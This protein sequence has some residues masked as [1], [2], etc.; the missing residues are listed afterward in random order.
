ML[1]LMRSVARANV[2]QLWVS[3]CCVVL[4]CAFLSMQ[5]TS[6]DTLLVGLHNF[7]QVNSAASKT[8]TVLFRPITVLLAKL[9]HELTATRSAHCLYVPRFFLAGPS[10]RLSVRAL[11][12]SWPRCVSGCSCWQW[13]STAWQQHASTWARLQAQP[14]RQ[15]TGGPALFLWFCLI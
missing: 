12:L 14:W 8:S 11:L 15:G 9:C 4:Q 13:P 1:A 3:V 7:T 2:W 10:C 6:W 5:S